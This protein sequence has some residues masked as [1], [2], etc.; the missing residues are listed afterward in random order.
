[1]KRIAALLLCALVSTLGSGPVQAQSPAAA[2]PADSTVIA[3][4]RQH[5]K[6]VFVIYQENR[7]F[8]SYFGTFPGAENLASPLAQSHGFRQHDPIGKRWITPFRLT[9][10]DTSDV[11]HAREALIAKADDGAMDRFVAVEEQLALARGKTLHDVKRL[12]ALTMAFEDCDT[13]P[14]LW[15]YASTFALFDHFFQAMYGPSTPGNLDLIAA[16]T[17]QTQLARHPLQRKSGPGPGEPV[18]DDLDPFLGPYKDDKPEGAGAQLDQTYATVMLTLAG[19]DATEAKIDN[20]DIKE[21]I[22]KIASLGQPAIPWGWYQEGFGDEKN[23]RESYV[24][25]HNAPQYFGYLRL[26]DYFWRGVHDLKDLLPAIQQGT[27]GDKGVVF[28]KGGYENPFGWKPANKSG[29]VQQNMLGDDDHPGYSDSHLSESLVATYVNAIARSKYWK[30]SVILITWDDSEGD[31]DHVPP[32]VFEK[33]P[34]GN[35]C[36]DGPRVPAII[37]SP[38]SKSHAIVSAP[39]DHA[40]FAK[41][42]GTLFNLP[43]L[44]SLPDEAPYLP[45]GPRD[46]NPAI[47]NLM[48]ALDPARLAGTTPPISSDAATIPDDAVTSF[49]PKMSCASLGITPVTIPGE[50]KIPAGFSPLP[51]RDDITQ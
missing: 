3:L 31:Y 9:T 45:Q 16:Q 4:A 25:H 12:G 49:P 1:M 21:D 51:T 29:F 27:L 11:N 24:T 6:H 36:G 14:F 23:A 50:N 7:S 8:D 2:A 38:F 43:S 10:A 41:F 46:G 40:S 34:D 32:P 22:Q 15:K 39:A 30:D 26:N 19:R 44:A 28:V 13:I 48:D 42:L 33:C 17:G 5:I 18:I 20:D 37:I 35:P 47:D